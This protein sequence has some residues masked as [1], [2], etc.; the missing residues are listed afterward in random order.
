MNPLSNI[1]KTQAELVLDL[2]KDARTGLSLKE[3]QVVEATVLRVLSQ[4]RAQ[5]LIDNKTVDVKSQLPLTEGETLYLK[6]TKSGDSQVLKMMESHKPVTPSPG[7]A[8]VRAL[9]QEGPY[10]ALA[11]ILNAPEDP[12][13]PRTVRA[14]PQD[15]AL[16]QQAKPA[17]DI[18]LPVGAKAPPL[19]GGGATPST[20]TGNPPETSVVKEFA[21]KTS[22]PMVFKTALLIAGRTPDMA[23][24]TM[25]RVPA[26]LIDTLN[27]GIETLLKDKGNLPV[28]ELKDPALFPQATVPKS[29][30]EIL[31][32]RTRALFDTFSAPDK[33]LM[34]KVLQDR[35]MTPAEKIAA[36]LR[37]A[38]EPQVRETGWTTI[39]NSLIKAFFPKGLPAE[40][41]LLLQGKPQPQA[42]LA[43][44]MKNDPP[45]LGAKSVFE[46]L[47]QLITAMALTPEAPFTAQT[48]KN[49][50]R[51]SGL[52]WES[53]LRTLVESHPSGTSTA[54]LKDQLVNLLRQDVKALSMNAQEQAKPET[55][56][57]VDTLKRFVDNVEKLQVLNSHSSEESGR[58]LLPLPFFSGEKL[59]F[60]QLF[61]DT[62]KKRKQDKS[63]EDR[64]IRV[65]FLLDMSR[66][67]HVEADF[68]IFKKA[69]S[70]EFVVGEP[71]VKAVLEEAFPEFR[72]ALAR[73]GYSVSRLECRLED[74][75]VLAN[76]S[77]ADRVATPSDGS[78]SIVI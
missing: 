15:G 3:N 4:G 40:P 51:N 54:S 60:G 11:K 23:G 32:A 9:G 43:L 22:I 70:G 14:A 34:E 8:L 33:Q 42:D 78:V 73:K 48:L 64:I 65:A 30:L 63:N 58:Y 25:P 49:L 62:D 24:A 57:A 74:P 7:L 53:K 68:A 76:H 47:K 69:L 20:P 45:A 39:K 41:D 6:V 72:D 77:L 66:L 10:E 31:S 61:I 13:L 35:T 37:P 29:A 17:L 12:Q 59:K 1:Q 44:G 21:A 46:S 27:T 56:K 16:A 36:L 75:G 67:G 55:E 19:Q 26:A 38:A 18:P 5:L 71:S 28:P 52:L 2:F 50:V